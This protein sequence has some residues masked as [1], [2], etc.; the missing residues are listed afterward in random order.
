MPAVNT[1]GMW[2]ARFR[3]CVQYWLVRLACFLWVLGTAGCA[4]LESEPPRGLKPIERERL[5]AINEWSMEGRVAVHA[6]KEAWHANVQWQHSIGQDNLRISGPFGQGAVDIAL[7]EQGIRITRS[8]GA[9]EVSDQ[10]EQLLRTQL[11]IAV[12]LSALRYWMLGVPEPGQPYTSKFDGMGY[13]RGLGQLGWEII[14]ERYVA[15]GDWIVP[16][17]MRVTK[18]DMTLKLIIDQWRIDPFA[19]QL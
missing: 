4:V 13:L 5:Y 15:E 17:K 8:D 6:E 12:P 19:A 18:A 11:G 14:Y 2:P 16:E 3:P 9:S 1:D 7:N 10:P